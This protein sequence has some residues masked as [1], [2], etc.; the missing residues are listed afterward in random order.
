MIDPQTIFEIHLLKKEGLSVQKIADR[1]K[2]SWLT[3]NKYL[4]NPE[5]KHKRCR[6]KSKLD[7]FKEEIKRM[8]EINSKA[9]AVV[10]RQ[11]LAEKGYNGGLTILKDYL[12]TI[13]K[14]KS[15]RAFVRFE[16]APGEQ[17]QIDWGHFG[18][19]TYSNDKRKLYCFV[20]IEAHSRMLYLEFTHSQN[21]ATLHRA[22]FSFLRRSF[23]QPVSI[24]IAGIPAP[25][26]RCRPRRCC[27]TCL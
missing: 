16:A 27:G 11:R 24:R 6:R 12:C 1:L 8:L 25:A 7:L 18:S 23:L 22:G 19:L 17:F 20:M 14:R 5:R 9:S 26:R 3:V 4:Q 21:Q 10:I 15:P 2:I 13:R